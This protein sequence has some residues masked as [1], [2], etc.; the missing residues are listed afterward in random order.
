MDFRDFDLKF[1]IMYLFELNFFSRQLE[2]GK[3]ITYIELNENSSI[4]P[5]DIH[6]Q[7]ISCNYSV[8]L[9]KNEK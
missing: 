9:L 1:T 3:L 7:R 6:K 5:T 4:L 8:S 2:N